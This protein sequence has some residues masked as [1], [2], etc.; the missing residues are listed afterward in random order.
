MIGRSIGLVVPPVVCRGLAP[1]PVCRG[2][3]T[4]GTREKNAS[5]LAAP[6]PDSWGHAP[7]KGKGGATKVV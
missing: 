5:S 7:Q 2:V 1:P 3:G 6:M 4:A